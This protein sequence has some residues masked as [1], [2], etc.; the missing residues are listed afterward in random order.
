MAWINVIDA[1][2]DGTLQCEAYEERWESDAVHRYPTRHTALELPVEWRETGLALRARDG[3]FRLR[4]PRADQASAARALVSRSDCAYSSV[5]S[6][7]NA[8]RCSA[9][10]SREALAV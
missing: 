10:I 5:N 1:D 9:S 7:D 3:R 8:W 6:P 4:L 2:D